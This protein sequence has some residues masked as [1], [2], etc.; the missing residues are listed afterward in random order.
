MVG[1]LAGP[2]QQEK[3]DCGPPGESAGPNGNGAASGQPGPQSVGGICLDADRQ[4]DCG[5]EVEE[6]HIPGSGW[7]C[8]NPVIW[9]IPTH[10]D[11]TATAA[12]SARIS[13]GHD[14]TVPPPSSGEGPSFAGVG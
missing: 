5:V 9:P 8:P 4:R 2:A 14:R 12:G 11:Q 3:S 7:T 13:S 6:S 1:D 10:P